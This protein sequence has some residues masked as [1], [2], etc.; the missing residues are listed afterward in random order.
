MPKEITQPSFFLNSE[1]MFPILN[2][3]KNLISEYMLSSNSSQ[4]RK[5]F[6][7][8]DRKVN[9]II[10]LVTISQAYNTNTPQLAVHNLW[11]K[12]KKKTVPPEHLLS[13]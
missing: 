6:L 10:L 3:N 7:N 2:R 4:L 5:Y 13:F 12:K 8:D 1:K 9:H 11:E